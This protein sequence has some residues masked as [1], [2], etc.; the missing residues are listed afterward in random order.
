VDDAEQG[1]THVVRGA[2][3]I[4]STPR[5]IHLQH[6]LGLPV[7]AYL[8]LPVAANAAG[9]KLSKQTL[10]HAVDTALPALTLAHVLEF[11]G[12]P[13]PAGLR[14]ADLAELWDWAIGNWR[15]EQLPGCAIRSTREL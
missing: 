12:H 8:H 10:A 5:Q 15:R 6:A 2:D 4:A 11:L 9:E 13:P 7:P 3:L 1:I 14:G